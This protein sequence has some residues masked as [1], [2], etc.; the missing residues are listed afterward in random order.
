MTIFNVILA[1]KIQL[2]DDGLGT[3]TC[4]SSFSVLMCNFYISALV[5]VLIELGQH[6]YV[7]IVYVSICSKTHS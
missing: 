4:R 1:R 3:E 6:I 5:V 7:S 2:P